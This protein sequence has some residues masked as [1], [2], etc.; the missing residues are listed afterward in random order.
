MVDGKPFM[1]LNSVGDFAVSASSTFWRAAGG[2]LSLEIR[3]KYL[4]FVT[5]LA[6][7]RCKVEEYTAVAS[8]NDKR[9]QKL[10]LK[11]DST[12]N[13]KFKTV[14]AVSYLIISCS[15]LRNLCYI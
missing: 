8:N 10:Q 5:N 6:G 1:Y 11:K 12:I 15:F 14:K 4:A 3:A 2:Y 13:V 9:E 7:N